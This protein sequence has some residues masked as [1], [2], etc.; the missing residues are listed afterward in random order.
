MDHVVVAYCDPNLL[1]MHALL[2]TIT[3]E[4]N[5]NETKGTHI[6]KKL[7]NKTRQKLETEIDMIICKCY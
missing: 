6:Q 3:I 2:I 5:K 4:A 7:Q 1:L